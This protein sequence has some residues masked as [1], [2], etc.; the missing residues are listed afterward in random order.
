MLVYEL[1]PHTSIDEV[2]A[3]WKF[4]SSSATIVGV[5][6]GVFDIG[7]I[8]GQT[9]SFPQIDPLENCSVECDLRILEVGKNNDTSLWAGIR[10]RGFVYD[11]GLGY[12]AY[13]RRTGTIELYRA[14]QVIGGANEPIVADT[15]N[16]W[17]KIRVDVFKSRMRVRVNGN[18]HINV[19]DKKFCD[20]GLV[21]L[22]TY[23]THAQFRNLRIFKLK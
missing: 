19:M 13:L 22:H 6:N 11:F 17:T 8:E 20:M 9:C 10:L 4:L 21:F 14:Y 12:L 23:F 1:G 18:L 7:S 15:E 3:D 16:S 5:S 2:R